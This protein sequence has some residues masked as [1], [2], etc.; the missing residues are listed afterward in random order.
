MAERYNLPSSH[1]FSSRDT[2]FSK[3][4]ARVTEGNGV[5]CVLNSLSGELLFASW[6]CVA[7]FGTFIEIGLRDIT[8]NTRLG[9]AHFRKNYCF[10]FFDIKNI[11]KNTLA[12]ILDR[13]VRLI[14]QGYVST[15]NPLTTYAFGQ[16]KEAYRTM[17]QGKHHGKL[18]LSLSGDVRVPLLLRVE[19]SLKLNSKATYLLIGG[20]GGLGRS[21]AQLFITSGARNIAFISRYTDT[22][23]QAKELVAKLTG[24]GVNIRVFRGDIADQESIL[25]ALQQCSQE[26][27]PIRGAIHLAAVLCDSIFEKL[28]HEEWTGPL[29]PKVQG[30]WNLHEYFNHSRPLDFF[31]LCASLSG[32]WGHASQS[33]YAAGNTYQDAL[34][35]YRRSAGLKAIAVDLGKS[36]CPHPGH[37]PIR[38][39][40]IAHPPQLPFDFIVASIVVRTD[41]DATFWCF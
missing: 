4:I 15:V 2:S 16:I 7:P 17:Q 22:S 20:L 24:Q 36:P 8:D 39:T 25:A 19:E 31:I 6:S 38:A 5:D 9:M 37:A 18:I 13:T 21:L 3:E 23:P 34:A 27:P 10:T 40:Q 14:R 30:S 1:I 12:T 28:S 32:I 29:R 41:H 35:H 26:L 33:A 11:P